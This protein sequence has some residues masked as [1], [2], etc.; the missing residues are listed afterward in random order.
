MRIST[1]LMAIVSVALM[2]LTTTSLAQTTTN[3]IFEKLSKEGIVAA[4]GSVATVPPP[5]MADGLSA[6]DQRKAIDSISEGNKNFQSLTNKGVNSPYVLKISDV[7]PTKGQSKTIRLVEFYF[8]IHADM[9][10][11]EEESFLKGQT[12]NREKPEDQEEETKVSGEEIKPEELKSLGISVA[13]GDNPPERYYQ[14]TFPLFGRVRVEGVG[15]SYYTKNENSSIAA[16]ILVPDFAKDQKYAA[17]WIPLTRDEKTGK[18]VEG[19]PQS[20]AG[21]GAYTKATILAEPKGAV[22]VEQHIL[23]DEP[24]GWFNGA[25]LLRSKLPS[26]GRKASGCSQVMADRRAI[27]SRRHL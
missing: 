14:G 26:H 10:R 9:K 23:F 11:L 7:K 21:A 5:V 19:K 27:Y 4:D 22:F 3:P 1:V 2:I 6:A 16:S 25:N 24:K 15:H 17:R 18:R 8:V 20:Y 13:A 12:E